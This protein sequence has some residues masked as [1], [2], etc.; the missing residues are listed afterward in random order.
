MFKKTA[1][2]ALAGHTQDTRGAAV[3]ID[4]RTGDILALASCPSFDPQLFQSA[5]TAEEYKQISDPE[6]MPQLNR[7]VWGD[8]C[9]RIDFQNYRRS[10][11]PRAGASIPRNCM[12]ASDNITFPADRSRLRTQQGRENSIFAGRFLKSSNCYFIDRGRRVGEEKIIE[13]GHRFHLSQTTGMLDKGEGHG[14]FPKLGLI[15][16]R[17]GSRWQ[18]GDTANLSIGQGEIAVTPLQMAVMT[19]AVANGGKLLRPRLIAGLAPQDKLSSDETRTFPNGVVAGDINVKPEYLALVRSAM[20]ADV[21][22][23]GRNWQSGVRR[24]NARMREDWNGSKSQPGWK[25]GPHH[26]VRFFCSV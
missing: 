7:A 4:V 16:K 2:T 26:L 12:T 5:V 22:D 14:Y 17:D 18:D 24:W 23:A 25:N 19:A 6:R 3:V 1:Y 13:M 15:L 8:L 11:G 21:E 9:S 10:R 20:L